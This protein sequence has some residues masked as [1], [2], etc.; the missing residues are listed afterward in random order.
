MN[1]T[2]FTFMNK[3][4]FK[5]SSYRMIPIKTHTRKYNEHLVFKYTD[6]N[7]PIFIFMLHKFVFS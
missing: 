4:V 3:L 5:R 6:H 2:S 1:D 7:L